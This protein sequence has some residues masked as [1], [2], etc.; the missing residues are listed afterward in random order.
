MKFPDPVAVTE[1][2][3]KTRSKILGDASLF[4]NGINE[5]HKVEKGDITFV[6]APKYFRKSLRSD[7]FAIL[8]NQAVPCPDGKVL[9]VCDN[10]FKAYNQLV[11][12]YRPR[13]PLSD[14]IS[15]SSSIH[16]SV[17]IEPGVIIG[18]H[19][20]IGMNCYIQANCYIGDY[21]VIGENV[22]IQPGTVIGNDAFYYQSSENGRDRLA[23]CGRVVIENN[24][25]IGAGCTIARGVS[26]DT[27]I[28]EGT[29]IDS[30]VLVGHGVVIGKNCLLAGQVGIGGKAIIEDG[31]ILYGQVGVAQRIR[32]GKGAVVSAKSGV[33]KN[34]AAGKHYF[35]IPAAEIRTR[36]KELAALRQ[37]PEFLQNHSE[38]LDG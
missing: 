16:P 10:P 27:I 31:V 32:I 5:I 34:L 19:V 33:S 3:Q 11:K 26:G 23:S 4:I 35:G 7:A 13:N 24:V 29:K 12:E 14:F 37:L 1:L 36:Q 28:G 30:Q 25:D 2:A 21:T 8:I 20:R 22:T 15:E 18:N 38:E 9:L 17:V 6:D